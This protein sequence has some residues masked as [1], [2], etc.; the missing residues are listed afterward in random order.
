M[1]ER[2]KPTEHRH[3]RNPALLAVCAASALLAGC[4]APDV[5]PTEVTPTDAS[6]PFELRA[7]VPP[8]SPFHGVHGLRFDA[9][10][11]LYAV[12]VIGQSMFTVDVDSG[13]VETLIGP[14]EGMG[15]DLAI[16]ADGTFVW[17]AIENGILYARAPGGPIRRVLE[18]YKGVNAVAFGPDGRRL[19]LSLVF[20][21]DALYEVDLYGDSPP[22]L[23]AEDLG[24][25][26]AFE[27]GSDGMIY[28]PLVFGGAVVKI[29][30]ETGRVETISDDFVSAGAL[31][32]ESATSALVLDD[33]EAIK[34]VD[35]TNGTTTVV[36]QLPAGADNLAI[37]STGRVFVSLSENNA[38]V[39]L[40]PET[41]AISYAVEPAPLTSPAGFAVDARG[42]DTL[43]VGDLFG[44]IKTIDVATGR[45][46]QAKVELF[47]PSRIAVDG[48]TVLGVSQ[49][50]GT[51][52]R[53]ALDDF[54]VLDTWEGFMRPGEVLPSPDGGLV[55]ADA[56]SGRVLR[57][58]P[59]GGS[60]FEVLATGLDEPTGLAPDG[61][62][63]V[64]VSETGAG[65]VLRVAL[66]GGGTEEIASGLRQPEGLAVTADGRLLVVDVAAKA[67][68][69][70]D[71]ASGSLGTLAADLPIG[72]ANGPSLYRD[73]AT[74]G[75]RIYFNSDIDN[76]IYELAE[77]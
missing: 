36:A 41:G 45:I 40:D 16:A 33:G 69:E 25:L 29:D 48:D 70:I 8:G 30:P 43:I 2:P 64:Y 21:G 74:S 58:A 60:E 51:I 61:N 55:V 38:I 14:P 7:V 75:E 72:L 35:L 57:A 17:T 32:L 65:R 49:V 39:E 15:D 10:D 53:F 63:A 37:D 24:G 3:I 4:G 26:N 59:G 27:V 66:D 18:G 5:T 54:S 9:D 68:V 52:Q 50:F 56:G 23:I 20:Y 71:P 34:R 28:G 11:Q 6:P 77:P 62:G 73:I 19:F 22:R 13:R 76:T 67:I 46:D 12:S 42:G 31:K 44:G 47:Q 1:N